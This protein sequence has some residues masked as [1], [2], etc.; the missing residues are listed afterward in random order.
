[1]KQIT[2]NIQDTQANRYEALF[3]ITSNI[4]NQRYNKTAFKSVGVSEV[5]VVQGYTELSDK[6][7]IEMLNKEIVKLGKI[8]FNTGGEDIHL[9]Y[10]S[11]EKNSKKILYI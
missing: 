10:S 6:E 8:I 7:I 5:I 11:T 1:M 2:I 3:Y 9:G 4:I